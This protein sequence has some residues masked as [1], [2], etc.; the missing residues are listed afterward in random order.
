MIWVERLARVR[1]PKFVS[2]RV[3]FLSVGV[4]ERRRRRRKNQF[5]KR[6]QSFFFHTLF[7]VISEQTSALV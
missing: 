1:V 3:L 2:D 4:S 7:Q 5:T 6:M